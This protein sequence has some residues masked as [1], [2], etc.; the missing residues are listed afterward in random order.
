MDKTQ[1]REQ[2][3][4]AED[5]AG[6]LEASLDEMRVKLNRAEHLADRLARETVESCLVQT[7]T[8]WYVVAPELLDE[9]EL[10]C[11]NY[12]DA[13]KLLDESVDEHGK[14]LIRV[15]EWS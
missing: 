15:R 13:R 2:L 11:V 3:R 4:N 9:G 6:R 12:L 5:A 7:G 10:E 14:R 1:L 8:G